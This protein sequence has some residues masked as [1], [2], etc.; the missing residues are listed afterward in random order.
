MP[1][2]AD[3]NPLT[4][5]FLAGLMLTIA[6]LLVR[7]RR[8]FARRN[9]A[10][11]FTDRYERRSVRASAPPRGTTGAGDR[12]EVEMH[13]TAR[14]LSAQLDAKMSALQALIRDADRAAQRLEA[15][16]GKATP[17]ADRTEPAGRTPASREEIY[18]LA[19]Y[20]FDSPEIARRTGVPVG[21]VELILGLR[22]KG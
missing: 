2:L 6:V 14:E 19:D 16:L 11:S 8:Y 3:S 5:V 9:Q 4:L 20:G 17:D 12:W 13:E 7:A 21:E 1:P 10:P 15:A 18:T 22:R